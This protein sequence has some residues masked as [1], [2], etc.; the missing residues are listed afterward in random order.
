M[1]NRPGKKRL[2]EI[3]AAYELLCHGL[4][5][6]LGRLTKKDCRVCP[7]FKNCQDCKA[8]LRRLIR[9]RKPK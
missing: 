4:L 5:F 6:D 8:E 9:E 1:K 2:F 3:I 7:A